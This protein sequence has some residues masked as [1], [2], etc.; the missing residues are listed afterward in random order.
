MLPYY[1]HVGHTSYADVTVQKWGLCLCISQS[2]LTLKTLSIFCI[3]PFQCSILY[4]IDVR[5]GQFPVTK[6]IQTTPKCILQLQSCLGPQKSPS[7]KAELES[8]SLR[9]FKYPS[10]LT[11]QTQRTL[12]Y[13]HPELCIERES[14]C[15]GLLTPELAPHPS[16][17]PIHINSVLYNLC[18]W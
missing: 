5:M 18:R 13:D 11:M 14:C 16:N 7:F 8:C 15:L 2:I 6:S 4:C 12:V 9:P 1:A 3:W 10:A 17:P